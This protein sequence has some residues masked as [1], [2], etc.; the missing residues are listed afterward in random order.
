MIDVEE[1]LSFSGSHVSGTVQ[2]WRACAE[3][4]HP[5]G[6]MRRLDRY[7]RDCRASRDA[8]VA[9]QH[10]PFQA[11]KNVGRLRN[12]RLTPGPEDGSVAVT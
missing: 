10:C 3:L 11:P 12:E 5:T 1:N 2:G 7:G 8:S 4:G 6:V 9:L